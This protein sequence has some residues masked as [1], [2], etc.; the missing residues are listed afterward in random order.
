[1]S[2]TKK[3]E[4]WR[5]LF[6]IHTPFRYLLDIAIAFVCT[7]VPRVG[8]IHINIIRQRRW[9]G[10]ILK[11]GQNLPMKRCKNLLAWCGVKTPEKYFLTFPACFEIPIIFSN[12]NNNCSSLSYLRNLQEQVKKAF[13]SCSDLSL[14]EQIVL[15]VTKFLQLIGLQP[16][17][18]KNVLGH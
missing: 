18:S 9:K 11:T 16:R 1:M 15:V 14:F 3:C 2:Q 7:Q 4:F 5:I 12:V 13:W 10:G 6:I 8:V 17:I